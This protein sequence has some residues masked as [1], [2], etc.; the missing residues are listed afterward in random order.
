V[1]TAKVKPRV[2]IS[3]HTRLANK[4]AFLIRAIRDRKRPAFSSDQPTRPNRTQA[5]VGRSSRGSRK[6]TRDRNRTRPRSLRWSFTSKRPCYFERGCGRFRAVHHEPD[7][8][9]ISDHSETVHSGR[10]LVQGEC[11]GGSWTVT[12]TGSTVRHSG[13]QNCRIK[14]SIEKA[15]IIGAANRDL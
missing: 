10:Q 1:N 12:R 14:T 9:S 15:P 6:E 8:A 2:P 5:A 3:F 11:G 7:R 4:P 13:D